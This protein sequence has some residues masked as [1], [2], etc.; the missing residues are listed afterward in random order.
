MVANGIFEYKT[1]IG[2]FVHSI[3]VIVEALVYQQKTQQKAQPTRTL[4]YVAFDQSGWSGG[5]QQLEYLR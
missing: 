4:V 5:R 1:N 3:E 2:Y